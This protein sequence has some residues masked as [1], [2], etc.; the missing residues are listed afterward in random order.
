MK[1]RIILALC[2][3]VIAAGGIGMSSLPHEELPVSEALLAEAMAEEPEEIIEEAE[4]LK[5]C[6]EGCGLPTGHEGE[7]VISE[8]KEIEVILK[9]TSMERDLKVKF[10]D[11]KTGKVI[12]GADFKMKVTS[13]SK[14]TKE[15]SDHDNDGIIWV[16]DIDGGNYTVAMVD[17]DG[18]VTAKTLKAEV[19][20]KIEYKV[21]E[22]EDEV[23]SESQVVVSQEDAAYGGTDKDESTS[24]AAELKDTVEFV[25][26]AKKEE[27][28]ATKVQK[29]DGFGQLMYKKQKV[30]ALGQPMYAK[31]LSESDEFHTFNSENVCTRC[32]VKKATVPTCT[33]V[34]A[35]DDDKCDSCQA[36][37]P[38]LHVHSVTDCK[39]TLCNKEI[40]GEKND[41]VCTV[42]KKLVDT[43]A[44][45]AHT[46]GSNGMC[47]YCSKV[48]NSENHDCL[49][50]DE[51]KKCD[52]CG[53]DITVSEPDEPEPSGSSTPSNPTGSELHTC[54]DV[55]ESDG[56]CDTCGKDVTAPMGDDGNED[57]TDVDNTIVSFVYRPFRFLRASSNNGKFIKYDT[58]S[59]PVYDTSSEPVYETET[60]TTYYGW[61]TIDGA[62]YYFDKHGEKVTG[63]QV[64]QGIS[65]TFSSEGVRSG[66]IGIDVSKY[67][68]GIN[69]TK[70][71]NAG[72]NFV[73]IRCGYRGYGSGVLVE[74]PMYRSHISGAK[75]A[76]L[77]V[78]VY[79][80]S[81][82]VNEAEAV[83]EASMAV[84]LAKKYGINMPIAIDSE[85]AAGGRGRADGL[86]KSARTAVTKAFCNTVRSAGYTPMVYASKAWFSD[87]LNVSQ[88]SGYYIWVAH[89]SEKCGYTGKYHIWQNTDKGKVDGV[90][91]RVD[92][93]ISF[94]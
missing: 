67:Q 85:Y 5:V 23:K 50:S 73:M 19:K 24:G 57:G 6:K 65:Y 13:P 83:E 33:H 43:A 1:K 28:K 78:G 37:V 4:E 40:H 93:N 72:I 59:A 11:K 56:K 17:L 20:K 21:V 38:D 91:G 39:C 14:T 42:C 31:I 81:Q 54:T 80:F 76:G 45:T 94:I 60:V 48:V 27:T 49:D 61:Q 71:K 51:N 86:S 3:L 32:G 9:S 70:V 64:I 12:S 55:E 75:A 16:K 7:C 66:S 2:S 25:E 10:V 18:Y 63:Q 15:Y 89:Y 62:T 47:Q 79:F 29:K 34:D 36:D 46:E 84:S 8:V 52:Q 53:A 35:N 26:S 58:S 30:D 22:I 74:D 69:W 88:L 82:A 90:P 77:R 92:M 87:H 68:T 41:G 44:H